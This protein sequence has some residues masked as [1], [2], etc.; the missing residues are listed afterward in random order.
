M[1][2]KIM[3]KQEIVRAT[4]KFTDREQPRQVF[5]DKYDALKQQLPDVDEIYV[6]TYYGVEELEKVHF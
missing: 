3:R 4:R 2:K 1:A 6:I 5:F